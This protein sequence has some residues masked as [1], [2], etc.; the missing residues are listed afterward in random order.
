MQFIGTRKGETVSAFEAVYHSLS[1]EGGLYAPV[2]FPCVGKE[3][4]AKLEDMSYAERA[5][6]ILSLYFEEFGE[7]FLKRVCDSAFANF[8]G[9]DEAPL[10]KIDGGRYVLELFHGKTCS[11][12]DL[13]VNIFAPLYKKAKEKLSKKEKSLVLAAT[14][15]NTGVSLIENFRNDEDT[16]IA[17]LYPE[18]GLSKMQR[19]HLCVQDGKRV[20]VAGITDT[21]DGCQHFIHR[22]TTSEKFGGELINRS[23]SLVCGNSSN[24]ARIIPEIVWY[25]SAYADL[26]SSGQIE[27]GTNVDFS[28][29]TGNLNAA[30]AGW[31]AKKMG[32]PIRRIIMP[33]NR[34]K[35]ALDLFTKGTLDADKAFRRSMEKGLDVAVPLNLERILFELS[36]RN[37]ASVAARMK[38]LEETGA[39]TATEEEIAAFSRDF[40]A[41]F[42]SEDD[43]LESMYNLF[44]EYGYPADPETGVAAAVADKFKADNEGDDTPLVLAATV[45]PYKC[46][47]DVLYCL[48]GNDV[49]DSYKGV[50]RLNL[51]TAM[52]PPKSITDVRYLQ[53]RFT[54]VLPP[55]G[56][57][58]TAAILS[59]L[60][61]NFV[62]DSKKKR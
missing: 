54:D 52:K 31:Y 26:C 33:F 41:D 15:G 51:L 38:L 4:R 48:S 14:S 59:F 24:V 40:Y 28:V 22:M 62:P 12:K 5:K 11:E 37:A 30:A 17:V 7:E 60:D 53:P 16:Y 35:A 27:D 32:L 8:E 34:N 49:K 39:L 21:F 57:K 9:K 23:F 20:Y 1:A 58:I 55:E 56:K 43:V 42:A 44:E 25:F 19:F 13:S 6:F 18:E 61:G 50:K 3:D 2:S 46:P 36:G 45:N 29:A 10:V 47:Q